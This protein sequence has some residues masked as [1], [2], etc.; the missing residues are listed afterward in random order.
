MPSLAYT[1]AMGQMRVVGGDA[2]GN[3]ARAVRMIE[4]AAAEGAA[5]I[6]LPECLDLG[7]THPSAHELAAPIPGDHSAVLCNA[8][9]ATGIYVVAGLV[10]RD[11]AQ[12]YNAAI[13][14][15]PDGTILLKHRKIN[16]LDFARDL[17]VIGDS[18][19]VA[20][21]ALG[22]IGVD[23]C[24]DNLPESL[25]IGR[26]L[27]DMGAQIIL[28]PSAWAVKGDHDNLKE[29]YGGLWQGAFTTLAKQRGVTIV[30]VSNVGTVD[31]GQWAGRVCVG[32]SLAVGS[33]G[34]V[35]AQG[36]Y[37]ASA[38]SLILI[39]I[40]IEVGDTAARAQPRVVTRHFDPTDS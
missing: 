19:S 14:I 20:H 15:A 21:T 35:I 29:P 4:Q 31:G 10:E 36:E 25:S 34:D 24:A 23:I 5:I 7:W 32:C 13:L 33:T 16:E 1:L 18:L 6:V 2:Q 11:G 9:R 8:A 38:E 37:N 40:E 26:T 30:G 22:G 39:P 17:Y 28:A 3:L 27:A 12:L